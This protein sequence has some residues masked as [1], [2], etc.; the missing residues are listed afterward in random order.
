MQYPPPP[1]PN[2]G[3]YLAGPRVLPELITVVHGTLNLSNGVI[4]VVTTMIAQSNTHDESGRPRGLGR[5]E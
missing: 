2:S 3:T 1:S 5:H 4:P